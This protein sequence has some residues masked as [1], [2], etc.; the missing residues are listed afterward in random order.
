MGSGPGGSGFNFS[1]ITTLLDHFVSLSPM[2]FSPKM[3]GG[4]KHLIRTFARW[5]SWGWGQ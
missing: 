3:M 1:R 5:L 4:I 2:S